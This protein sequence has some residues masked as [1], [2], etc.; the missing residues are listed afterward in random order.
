MMELNLGVL[1]NRSIKRL[2]GVDDQLVRLAIEA[3][4]ISP[5]P[6]EITEGRRNAD[7]QRY[8]VS[9][10]KSRTMESKHLI[11]KAFDF[12]AMPGGKVS[13]LLDDYRAVV[14]R[15]FKTA[16]RALQME[17]RFDYG[18]YWRSIID[19]PHVELKG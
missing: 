10:G 12:V 9:T 3:R 7:R 5:I 11:G 19:G 8:L 14:E 18:C 16:E 2:Y 15:G 13:W 1:S 6:F 17:G 4:R